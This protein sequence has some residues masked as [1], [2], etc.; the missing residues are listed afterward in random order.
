MIPV[1]QVVTIPQSVP[2]STLD[3]VIPLREAG[4]K[5]KAIERQLGET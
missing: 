4:H 1:I 3:G 2:A 5:Y